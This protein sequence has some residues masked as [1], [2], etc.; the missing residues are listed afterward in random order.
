MS[1]W[2]VKFIFKL[3]QTTLKRWSGCVQGLSPVSC[4]FSAVFWKTEGKSEQEELVLR[5][6]CERGTKVWV[7]RTVDPVSRSGGATLAHTGANPIVWLINI[8]C[9]FSLPLASYVCSKPKK[10]ISGNLEPRR[11]EKKKKTPLDDEL[12]FTSVTWRTSGS[13]RTRGSESRKE[14]AHIL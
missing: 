8:W 11:F 5:Q 4:S 6:A 1:L 12:H 3:N 10:M 2:N 13:V 9:N 7:W 14:G